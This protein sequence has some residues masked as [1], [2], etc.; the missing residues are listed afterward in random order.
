MSQFRHKDPQPHLVR[1]LLG[2]QDSLDEA[3]LK[4]RVKA[5]LLGGTPR[6]CIGRFELLRRLGQGGEGTVYQARDR[7][8][9][10]HV[11]LKQLHPAGAASGAS[12]K[13]EFRALADLVHPNLV[14]LHELFHVGGQ[15]FYTME[16]VDGVEFVAYARPGGTLSCDRLRAALAQL[17]VG[18]DA[19]HA[20]DKI[21][22]DLKPS[23]V[24][25]RADGR[26]AVLDYGL[27]IDRAGAAHGGMS[28][29]PAYAA[30]EQVAGRAEAASD[31][32]A[33]GVML[34]QALTGTLPLAGSVTT[35][36]AHKR[37]GT[38]R[39][40]SL[41]EHDVPPDLSALCSALLAPDLSERP[42]ARRA[43]AL[44]D[45][46]D[47]QRPSAGR[48]RF[49]E[50]FV[51]RRALLSELH[52]LAATV[53]DA[54]R[55]VLLRGESGIG[56]TA[57][58]RRFCRERG[59][60]GAVVLDGRCYEREHM[61]Y[62]ALDAIVESLVEHLHA[63]SGGQPLE[64]ADGQREA[65]VRLFPAFARLR[66]RALGGDAPAPLGDGSALRLRAFA[67]VKALFQIL[68][69]AG[70]VVFA[71][72]DLKWGDLDSI[73]LLQHV[74][75]GATAPHILLIGAYRSDE[76]HSS[77]VMQA[78]VGA[79]ALGEPRLRRVELE[80]GPLP[81]DEADAL[82]RALAPGEGLLSARQLDTCIAQASGMPFALQQLA[83]HVGDSIAESSGETQLADVVRLRVQRCSEGARC[84][85]DVLSVAG[86]PLETQLALRSC[87]RPDVG[88]SEAAELCGRK[89]A[90]WRDTEHERCLE[91][92][93][94]LVRRA[95]IQRLPKLRTRAI[96]VAVVGALEVLAPDRPERLVEHLLGAEEYERAGLTALRAA[97]RA[98]A[99]LAWNR[100][101]E[102]LRIAQRTLS[103]SQLREHGVHERLAVALAS[104]SRH[105]QS[106]I[107][108][109]GAAGLT[110]SPRER[111]RLEGMAAMQHMRAGDAGRGMVLLQK[112][113]REVGFTLPGSD[114]AALVAWLLNR[115][116]QRVADYTTRFPTSEARDVDSQER[117]QV[118]SAAFSML[119]TRES[120]HASV[121]HAWLFREARNAR[122]D[123]FVRSL[124]SEVAYLVTRYGP[125]AHERATRLMETLESMQAQPRLPYTRALYKLARAL[126]MLQCRWEP[127]EALPLLTEADE[128][129]ALRCPGTQL[130]RGWVW[131]M[132]EFSLELTGEFDVLLDD[133]AV[134]ERNALS[135]EDGYSQ[136]QRLMALPLARTLHG[137]ADGA[138]A[139]ARMHWKP[140]RVFTLVD[141]TVVGRVSSALL[142]RGDAVGAH[143]HLMKWWSALRR[144]GLLMLQIVW[145]NA[146]YHR[147]RNAAALYCRTRDSKLR[148]EAMRRVREAY[149]YPP[150]SRALYLLIE[151]SLA[152]ADRRDA[153]CGRLLR[154]VIADSQAARAAASEWCARYRLAQLEGN[155]D[156]LE[157][158]HAWHRERC[159]AE[160]ERWISLSA[161]GDD[162]GL[163]L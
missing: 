119:W 132:R 12:L 23:N 65:L 128:E 147:A 129:F 89:L 47:T 37:D 9:G 26:V 124:S 117:I 161:P 156:D 159:V 48:T 135:Q 87:A 92:Y 73:K 115:A 158:A 24:L 81:S 19:L 55:V 58:L 29:T 17:L 75:A 1:G 151:A 111:R 49:G 74:L 60:A 106:A 21:H 3:L 114:L 39:P 42:T 134:R 137:D 46:G 52:A 41:D 84:L 162:W 14:V 107:A 112:L 66:T 2:E 69:A 149:R 45:G 155:R 22:R 104:I 93:H 98:G 127:R 113:L 51:G 70:E 160:P 133:L 83:E 146:W 8:G 30:P 96:H 120:L 16:L 53:E 94:D 125:R 95:V 28:G 4:A 116:R 63:L 10:A 101:A 142:Y 64:L 76:L 13:R 122:D 56:K 140:A 157:A 152:R 91:P 110:E 18:L 31:L 131:A 108:Y 32:Y 11:A 153:E 163:V 148:R 25:V 130:E 80:V 40:P 6:A 7:Q 139:F 54:P 35:L 27:V 5:R 100:A 43:L 105:R 88:W 68:A 86:H 82:L 150:G 109:V 33:V 99:Q 103:T 102:L 34:F 141:Y 38:A 72:D 138:I 62:K 71:V 126:Y 79:G 90:R 97:E 67:G 20:A 78:I 145:E 15:W 85:L 136:D 118:L 59:Q 50:S 77:P 44:C 143:A 61:P 36:L 121:V 123:H 154:A 144:S 57:L